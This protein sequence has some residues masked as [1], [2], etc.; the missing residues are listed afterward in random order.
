MV[1][2]ENDSLVPFNFSLV[3]EKIPQLK[4]FNLNLTVIS[5]SKPIDS[6]NIETS[7]WAD[8]A[9][10]IF[11]NYHQYNGF[12]VLHGTD[13]MAYSASAL[14][15]MLEGLNKPVIFTG[16]QIPI[17]AIRSD[18]Q[19][20]LITALEIIASTYQDEKPIINEVCL[21]FNFMLLRGNRAQKIRSSTFGAFE[22]ENYPHLARSGV[23]IEYN[24]AFLMP[25]NG[26]L[27]INY[28]PKMD[29]NVVIFKIF[30]NMTKNTVKGIM[31]INGLKAVILETYGSGNTIKT[32]WFINSLKEAINKGI[33]IINVSQCL[34]G[35]VIQGKYETSCILSDIGVISG[36]DITTEAA[37]VKIMYLLANESSK[38]VIKEKMEKSLR[39]E[40]TE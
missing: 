7:H 11:N 38:K 15:F 26:K 3:L 5:F 39:G 25:H 4:N 20:N 35:S 16:A 34:G 13:T 29:S 24:H 14:S 18:A 32:K 40:I 33:F 2:D 28:T 12:V 19:E 21:Y 17:G 23:N 10:I 27:K 9:Y 1:Y 6:T 8:I 37:V 36:H 31:N 30:P 22:S